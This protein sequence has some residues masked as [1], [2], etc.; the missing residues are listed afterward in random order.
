MIFSNLLK[1]NLKKQIKMSEVD[2]LKGVL[3]KNVRKKIVELQEKK[4]AKKNENFENNSFYSKD[5]NTVGYIENLKYN[6]ELM[7]SKFKNNSVIRESQN[8]LFTSIDEKFKNQMNKDVYD[9][10]SQINTNDQNELNDTKKY[11]TTDY[12]NN[13][14]NTLSSQDKVRNQNQVNTSDLKNFIEKGNNTN[15][16]Y[17]LITNSNFDNENL[18]TERSKVHFDYDKVLNKKS[19]KKRNVF[20]EIENKLK[21]KVGLEG[22][23]SITMT[24]ENLAKFNSFESSKSLLNGNNKDFSKNTLP[25]MKI[26]DYNNDK[27]SKDSNSNYLKGEKGNKSNI[28]RNIYNSKQIEL[29]LELEEN[30]INK[31]K[32]NKKKKLTN[33]LNRKDENNIN[34]TNYGN[35]KNNF[36]LPDL[37]Q[38]YKIDNSHVTTD[39]NT[40]VQLTDAEKKDNNKYG[41]YYFD[42]KKNEFVRNKEVLAKTANN[43]NV[44]T[45]LIKN[46]IN[47]K[48]KSK[49]DLPDFIK[50]NL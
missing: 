3:N 18:K 23:N 24:K 11:L 35:K 31:D 8:E 13:V 4:M 21:L 6:Y 12:S 39:F 30:S 26:T 47:S 38:F 42:D 15:D 43:F 46:G 16:D 37:K 2:I 40:L 29:E 10:K 44:K 48:Q 34:Y 20:E 28:L 41:K 49:Y 9:Q 19:S 7:D 45:D 1:E 27:F 32:N 50:K 36:N 5:I 22:M 14:I 25:K 17:I 33:N